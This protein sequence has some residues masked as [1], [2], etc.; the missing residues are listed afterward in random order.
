[1]KRYKDGKFTEIPK[2]E[3]EKIQKSFENYRNK[4]RSNSDIEARVKALE[5]AVAALQAKQENKEEV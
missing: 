3:A 4:R 1:M 5:E 2:E